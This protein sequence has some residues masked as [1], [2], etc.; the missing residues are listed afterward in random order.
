MSHGVIGFPRVFLTNPY[1]EI[2]RND[3]YRAPPSV[4]LREGEKYVDKD[5]K[6][7]LLWITNRYGHDAQIEYN[8]Q[9]KDA[10]KKRAPREDRE[11]FDRVKYRVMKRFF[12]RMSQT[13][14]NRKPG[15]WKG[16]KRGSNKSF[17]GRGYKPT[18]TR[19]REGGTH[20]HKRSRR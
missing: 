12:A 6:S 15:T 8:R 2:E 1:E 18:T 3:L 20:E 5:G 10:K 16:H 4:L 11:D 7:R 14:S 19:T 13:N 17:R 9:K